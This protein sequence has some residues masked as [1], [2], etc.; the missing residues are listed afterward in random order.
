[1]SPSQRP[2]ILPRAIYETVTAE[3]SGRS[4][5]QPLH[6]TNRCLVPRVDLSG[7]LLEAELSK[8]K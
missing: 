5:P 8:G 2:E 4:K 1:M 7:D 3:N 6:H